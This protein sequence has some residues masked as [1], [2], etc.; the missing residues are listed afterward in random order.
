MRINLEP[1]AAGFVKQVAAVRRQLNAQQDG[2][3]SRMM[4][5]AFVPFLP[6]LR[7]ELR[8]GEVD[9]VAVFEGTAYL[10][11]NIAKTAVQ[12]LLD[13]P[14]LTQGETVEQLLM[15]ACHIACQAIATQELARKP[16]LELVSDNDAPKTVIHMQERGKP[17][18]H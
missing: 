16:K 7:T 3:D 11:A 6:A 14:A 1:D 8:Q 10:V 5:A 12:S 9:P 18:G 13:A 4:T 2:V 17:N 15:K